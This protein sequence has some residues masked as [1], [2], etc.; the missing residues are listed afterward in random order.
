LLGI[1]M[2]NV[3]SMVT[4]SRE[5]KKKLGNA[6]YIHQHCA[7]HIFNIAIQYGL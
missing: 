1:M 6:E 3:T 4:A 7:T 2:N 5:L